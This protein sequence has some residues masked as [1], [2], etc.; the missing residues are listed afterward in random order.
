MLNYTILNLLVL[1]L[2]A[3]LVFWR[4]VTWPIKQLAIIILVL[5]VL[6]AIFDTLIIANNIVAYDIDKII[7]VYI[8]KAPIED[9]A[10][11]VAAT[12]LVPYIWIRSTRNDK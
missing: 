11:A 4:P 10:Y 1:G 2:L 8:G 6:T 5:L 3:G 9:F 12:V 7:G